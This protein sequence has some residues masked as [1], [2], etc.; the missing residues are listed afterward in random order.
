MQ[1]Y[2]ISKHMQDGL[3]MYR[4]YTVKQI[5]YLNFTLEISNDI[6][7]VNCGII[8]L[9]NIS[10]AR[11]AFHPHKIPRTPPTVLLSQPLQNF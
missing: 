10:V 3:H 1:V 11:V 4:A 2:E 6:Y 7:S 5:F 8:E 9:Q